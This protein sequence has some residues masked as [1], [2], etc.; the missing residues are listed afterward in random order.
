MPTYSLSPASEEEWRGL[1]ETMVENPEDIETYTTMGI[2]AY[3]IHVPFLIITSPE[4]LS[5]FERLAHWKRRK[6]IWTEVVTTSDIYAN[7]EGEDEAAKI[8]HFIQEYVA[9]HNTDYVLLGGGETCMHRGCKD[10][11][12]LLG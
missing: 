12:C 9:E 6:G 4:L 10:R 7:C 3:G 11:L 8:K 1:V 2:D 5:Q